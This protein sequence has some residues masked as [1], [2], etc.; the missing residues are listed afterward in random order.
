[1][2]V[3]PSLE[4]YSCPYQVITKHMFAIGFFNK[5][6]LSEKCALQN[7]KEKNFKGQFTGIDFNK[8]NVN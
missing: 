6:Y 5:F 8:I 2:L 1:M 4:F 3:K 7:V